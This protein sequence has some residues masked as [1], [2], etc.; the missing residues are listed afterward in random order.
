M[1]RTLFL[2]VVLLLSGVLLMTSCDPLASFE[3]GETTEEVIGEATAS[4]EVTTTDAADETTKVP[5][6][7]PSKTEAPTTSKDPA[8]T[9][10]PF[11]GNDITDPPSGGDTTSPPLNEAGANTEDGW[12]PILTP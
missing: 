5:S 8:T 4:E 10:A 7:V 11:G 2:T 12:G 1:K 6:K 3:T 9:T